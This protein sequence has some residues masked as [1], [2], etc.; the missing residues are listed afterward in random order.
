MPIKALDH[1]NIVAADLDETMAFYARVLG[2]RPQAR[3]DALASAIPDG[4]LFD[5]EG[6]ALIHLITHDV[7]RHGES[8]AS[9]VAR[10]PELDAR[11]AHR[12]GHNPD[13][14]TVAVRWFPAADSG[15]TR[16]AAVRDVVGQSPRTRTAVRAAALR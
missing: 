12:A 8:R 3:P 2:L 4:W 10:W 13:R 6:R 1:V 5:D 14:R 9:I 11:L 15:D 7:A 16:A